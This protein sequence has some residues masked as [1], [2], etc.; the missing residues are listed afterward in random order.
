MSFKDLL[1]RPDSLHSLQPTHGFAFLAFGV[2]A[3]ELLRIQ[4]GEAWKQEL[5]AP[6]GGLDRAEWGRGGG[7]GGG[8]AGAGAHLM[9]LGGELQRWEMFCN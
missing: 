8:V 3:L 1:C 5:P 2:R 6:L 7:G 9:Y 4:S